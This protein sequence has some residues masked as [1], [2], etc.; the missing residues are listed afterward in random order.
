MAD[1]DHLGHLGPHLGDLGPDPPNLHPRCPRN[2]GT[3]AG[4]AVRQ[5]YIYIYIFSNIYK[6]L[7][8]TYFKIYRKYLFRT[9]IVDAT[10]DVQ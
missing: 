8:N 6:K 2:P 10:D 1:L 3:V 5:L 7:Q 4:L 9:G